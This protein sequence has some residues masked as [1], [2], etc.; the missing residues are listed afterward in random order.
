MNMKNFIE[1]LKIILPAIITGFLHF[2]LLN[3]II[4]KMYR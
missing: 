3:T 4:V 1:I 2:L